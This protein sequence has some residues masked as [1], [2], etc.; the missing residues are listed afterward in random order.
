MNGDLY[1][2]QITLFVVHFEEKHARQSS[3][4]EQLAARHLSARQKT[5]RRWLAPRPPPYDAS[6]EARQ[7]SISRVPPREAPSQ[8]AY[9]AEHYS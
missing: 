2:D 7:V 3:Q 6:A 8:C 1:T 4:G 9:T 5:D